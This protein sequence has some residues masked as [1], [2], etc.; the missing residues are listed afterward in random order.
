MP[1][2]CVSGG[3]LHSHA[4][5]VPSLLALR[6]A[7]PAG[8]AG[9]YLVQVFPDLFHGQ[10]GEEFLLRERF[11]EFPTLLRVEMLPRKYAVLFL[12]MRSDCPYSPVC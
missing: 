2:I 4:G 3:F 10:D 12:A 9:G 1:S 5:N 6:L 8:A 7:R 11:N